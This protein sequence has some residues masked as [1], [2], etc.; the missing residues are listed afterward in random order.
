LGIN[1]LETDI[2]V[3]K[4]GYLTEGLYDIRADWMMALTRGGVD[5]DLEKLP[6]KNIHRPMFPLDKEMAD[7]EFKVEFIPLSK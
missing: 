2:I 6:Y 4:L 3:V 7:P 1:P 5:Q